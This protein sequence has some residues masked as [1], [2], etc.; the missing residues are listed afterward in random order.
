MMVLQIDYNVRMQAEIS[1]V[2]IDDDEHDADGM[3]SDIPSHP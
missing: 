3:Y 2:T 1:W